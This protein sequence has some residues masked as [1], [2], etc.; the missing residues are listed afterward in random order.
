MASSRIQRDSG[1][2]I[3]SDINIIPFVDICLVLMIIF[4]V[5]ANYIKYSSIAI[6]MPETKHA[7]S[8]DKLNHDILTITISRDGPVYIDDTLLTTSKLKQK[9]QDKHKKNPDISIFISADKN[10]NFKHVVNVLDCLSE[11]GIT[12][13]NVTTI[14]D[15]R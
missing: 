8:N 3:L 12:K 6:N 10:T 2:D 14:N 5:T 7:Q 15:T 11:L 13:I 4:M 1:D 9:I